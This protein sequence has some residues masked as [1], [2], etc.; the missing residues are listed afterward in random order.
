[1]GDDDDNV[2]QENG[3]ETE[4]NELFEQEYPAISDS[5]VTTTETSVPQVEKGA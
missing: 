4:N 1:M 3:N 5:N 2:I